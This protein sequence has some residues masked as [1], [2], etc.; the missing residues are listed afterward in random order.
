M[1]FTSIFGDFT[2]MAPIIILLI[3]ALIMPAV[4]FVGK[5]PTV[6]WGV[7]LAF[8]AVSLIVN[9]LMLNDAYVGETWGVYGYDAYTGLMVLLFQIVLLLTVLV[10]NS[11]VETTRLHVGAYYALLA[12][13]TTGMMF[14][15]GSSDLLTILLLQLGFAA[16]F[17]LLALFAFFSELIAAVAHLT[18]DRTNAANNFGERVNPLFEQV[19]AVERGNDAFAASRVDHHA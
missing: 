13:A 14:V 7:A 8:T 16:M 3:G 10:S 1:D 6:T 15:A 5:R 18:G 12:G 4:Q 11:S 17:L 2:A 19:F 9:I